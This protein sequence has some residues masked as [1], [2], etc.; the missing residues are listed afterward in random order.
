MT[1]LFSGLSLL[2]AE[3]ETPQPKR[4]RLAKLFDRGQPAAPKKPQ[5]IIP[6][7]CSKQGWQCTQHDETHFTIATKGMLSLNIH[8][9]CKGMAVSLLAVIGDMGL[10]PDPLD[11]FRQLA[12]TNLKMDI[13]KVAFD[14]DDDLAFMVELP[15]LDEASFKE[16]I[17]RI[18]VYVLKYL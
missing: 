9:I 10:P 2:A 14:S 7:L 15:A 11:L 3:N 12:E 1:S 8:V 16:S 18:Q 17:D 6:Q 4:S 13:C 5:E